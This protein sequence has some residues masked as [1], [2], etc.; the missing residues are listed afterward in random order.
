MSAVFE[1]LFSSSLSSLEGLNLLEAS[2]I[3]SSDPVRVYTK[4]KLATKCNAYLLLPRNWCW[5][6]KDTFSSHVRHCI[7]RCMVT[8]KVLHIGTIPIARPAKVTCLRS[9]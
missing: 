2:G 8:R 6:T 9:N 3:A 1:E 4:A 7:R 5:R